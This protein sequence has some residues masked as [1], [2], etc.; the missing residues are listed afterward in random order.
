MPV[1]ERNV[2]TRTYGHCIALSEH[3]FSDC[4]FRFALMGTALSE[5]GF[6]DCSFRFALM[7]TA[8]SE[9]RFSDCSFRFALTGTALSKQGD[10]SYRCFL[11]FQCACARGRGGGVPNAC[12][13]RFAAFQ[14]KHLK[15]HTLGQVNVSTSKCNP[16]A[17]DELVSTC[18]QHVGSRAMYCNNGNH[19]TLIQNYRIPIYSAAPAKVIAAW[20]PGKRAQKL[21]VGCLQSGCT[22]CGQPHKHRAG[23]VERW[24]FGTSWLS[25]MFVC[26][27]GHGCIKG[28]RGGR[29]WMYVGTG[30]SGV[31]AYVCLMKRV[32]YFPTKGCG[33]ENG[34]QR[35]HPQFRTRCS[36][37][38]E[39]EAAYMAAKP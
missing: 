25:R 16:Q 12:L 4:S 20:E 26:V 21:Y 31:Q 10:L 9:H 7:G 18:L 36:A 38:P 2:G 39:V 33:V 37:E 14:K 11:D 19:S 8:F 23:R 13:P 15:Q 29:K 22:V 6:S 27:C 3:G 17:G 5:H 35:C 32:N 28:C 24:S 30:W 34:S 1:F